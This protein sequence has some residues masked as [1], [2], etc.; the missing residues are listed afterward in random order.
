MKINHRVAFVVALVAAVAAPVLGTN[1]FNGS[2]PLGSVA[3]S[4]NG[5]GGG[6]GGSVN[7]GTSPQVAYYSAANTIDSN[8]GLSFPVGEA[9]FNEAGAAYDVRAEGDT[10]T[11]LFFI[12]GS[13]D[14]I[15]IAN[16]TPTANTIDSTM[17]LFITNNTAGAGRVRVINSNATG[18]TAVY[19]G[20]DISNGTNFGSNE[21]MGV[22]WSSAGDVRGPGHYVMEANGPATDYISTNLHIWTTGGAP[23]NEAS[24][25]NER[26]RISRTE[27]VVNEPGNDFDT[28]F[29]SDVQA[30]SFFL[31]GATGYTN[32]GKCASN[33]QLSVTD[34]HSGPTFIDVTNE[35]A[36][37]TSRSGVFLSVDLPA[38]NNFASWEQHSASW[39][40]SGNSLPSQFLINVGAGATNGVMYLMADTGAPW[41][42]KRGPV[43][44]ATSMMELDD[45]AVFNEDGADRDF[46][47][48]GDTTTHLIFGDASLEA[49]SI[50]TS[51]ATSTIFTTGLGM[52][53]LDSGGTLRGGTRQDSGGTPGMT[54]GSTTGAGSR[55]VIRTVETD[56]TPIRMGTNTNTSATGV[57]ATISDSLSATSAGTSLHA[58]FGSGMNAVQQRQSATCAAGVLALDPTSSVV[59]V[60]PA[61]AACAVTLAEGSANLGAD[62]TITVVA[63]SGAG[64][65][66]FP[67]VANIHA[68]PTLCTTTGLTENGVYTITYVDKTNDMYVGKSCVQN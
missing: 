5:G 61:G 31:D 12:D 50:G 44:G 17:N 30:C 67:N 22:N 14:A 52:N 39:T 15:G 42:V 63:S 48:E 21:V 45:A 16:S 36:S 66:T 3:S 65:V 47:V 43:I 23:V 46:R 28:R 53:F 57:V 49:V 59:Y 29:E 27:L 64:V 62:V 4:G 40:A 24:A 56:N 41:A 51:T 33:N 54:W 55:P 2:S 7:P 25:S 9:V 13:A 6:G 38:A 11:H 37:T 10:Q 32:L 1:T 18:G 26:L 35:T 34:S 8:P 19:A 68:G 20:I 58:W 60:D